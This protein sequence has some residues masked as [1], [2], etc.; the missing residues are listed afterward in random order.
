MMILAKDEE[1]NIGRFLSSLATQSLFDQV[2]LDVSLYVVSNGSS[3]RTAQIARESVS[4]DLQTRGVESKILDWPTPGKSRSWNR[5]VHEVLPS[6]VDYIMA[7]D[8]DIEFVDDF[9]LAAMFDRISGDPKLEV[10]S[11]FPVKDIAHDARPTLVNRFSR[12]VSGLTRHSGSI[13]GSLYLAKASCLN[14]IWLPDETPGEDGF[15]NAMVMTRGFSRPE[16]PDIVY[17][18]P[19][20]THYFESHS[21]QSYFVHEKRMIV[22]TMINRWIFEYLH[23]LRLSEPAG[24]LIQRLNREQPNWVE[25]IIAERSPGKW[26]IPNDLLFRRLAPKHGLSMSYLL[27]LPILVLATALTFPPALKANKALKRRGA[28]S[29]W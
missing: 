1:R 19:E 12:K 5:V 10:V 29:L 14:E 7:I 16:D 11:G 3:D 20:P 25:K 21:P 2:D 4:N 13:N 17:Q 22:G 15:L 23:S 27:R 18:L 6:D 9:V 28:S 24:P 26:L 8:A